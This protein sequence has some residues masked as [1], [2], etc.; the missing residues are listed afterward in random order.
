MAAYRASLVSQVNNNINKCE[1]ISHC[2]IVDH[3]HTPLDASFNVTNLG[4]N[5]FYV[6]HVISLFFLLVTWLVIIFK[7]YIVIKK[8]ILL[9]N[10]H[11]RWN[12]DFMF[13]FS[14]LLFL[15]LSRSSAQP[16]CVFFFFLTLY[17][18]LNQGIFSITLHH[19]YTYLS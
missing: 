16:F 7:A 4:D 15:P 6:Y 14:V 11:V 12:L 3:P 2:N 19:C 8:K 18:I 9:V 10:S 5:P 13:T 17:W 1:T